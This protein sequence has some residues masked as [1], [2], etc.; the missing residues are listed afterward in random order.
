[1]AMRSDQLVA[2]SLASE[3]YF[4]ALHHALDAPA[5]TRG[6]LLHLVSRAADGPH[7]DEWLREARTD[8]TS[9]WTALRYR[10]YDER[11]VVRARAAVQY[12]L[13]TCTDDADALFSAAAPAMKSLEMDLLVSTGRVAPE[14]VLAA[15]DFDRK[16]DRSLWL[17]WA[18]R[19]AYERAEHVI[20]LALIRAA[21]RFDIE[22]AA[23]FAAG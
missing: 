20:A 9:A 5:P 13:D 23:R 4:V 15:G 18:A 12:F 8:A 11:A 19:A 6:R 2:D 16:T 10:G 7:L 1:M 14:T 17:R 21:A 22:P 3:D